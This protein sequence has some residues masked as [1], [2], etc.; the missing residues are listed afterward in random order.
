MLACCDWLVNVPVDE[1]RLSQETDGETLVLQWS[2]QAQLPL[3]FSVTACASGF[4]SPAVAVKSSE[5]DEGVASAQGGCTVRLMVIVCG[6]PL[7]GEPRESVAAIT[8][9]PV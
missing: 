1:E 7:A 9:W 4:A 2:G 3:P 5:L 6:L 8:T